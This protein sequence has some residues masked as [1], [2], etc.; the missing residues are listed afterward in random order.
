MKTLRN[1][2][3][4]LAFAVVVSIARADTIVSY[5]TY[6]ASTP[7]DFTN[8]ALSPSVP[9][10]NTSLGTLH[11]VT[12]KLNVSGSAATS[13]SETPGTK[14]TFKVNESSKVTLG[15]TNSSLNTAL[16][17]L[18]ETVTYSSAITTLWNPADPVSPFYPASYNFGTVTLTG[19]APTET[20]NVAYLTV[21]EGAG[22]LFFDATSVSGYSF[23]GGGNNQN[24]TISNDDSGTVTVTYDYTPGSPP[25]IP[26]P[27]TLTLFGTGLLGLAGALRYKFTKSR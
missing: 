25:I 2:L 23:S 26:E 14:G 27:S 15:S 4:I 8:L 18:S 5:T 10:F 3:I 7:T 17:S 20:I 1:S 19:S 13:V 12:V 11:S 22:S 16:N 9:E 24:A 21:F 6:L